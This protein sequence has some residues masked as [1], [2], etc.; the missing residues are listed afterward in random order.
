MLVKLTPG[1]VASIAAS[2]LA[3]ICRDL[4]NPGTVLI[5]RKRK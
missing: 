5:K 1:K 3:L 2:I 4:K